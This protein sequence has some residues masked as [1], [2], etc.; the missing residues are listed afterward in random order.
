MAVGSVRRGGRGTRLRGYVKLYIGRVFTPDQRMST[1][2]GI[3]PPAAGTGRSSGGPGR[4]RRPVRS[5]RAGGAVGARDDRTEQSREVAT[6]DTV[7]GQSSRIIHTAARE[8]TLRQPV[9]DVRARTVTRQRA[10]VQRERLC[11]HPGNA[12]LRR[13]VVER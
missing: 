10:L 3:Q 5:A 1:L 7:F 11:A 2:N 8:Q 13:Q 4:Q 6:P 12:I 9:P